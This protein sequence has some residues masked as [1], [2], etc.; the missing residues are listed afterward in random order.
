MART[1]SETPFSKKRVRSAG[2]T[3]VPS[4]PVFANDE[5]S[6]LH[7]AE[8]RAHLNLDS[9]VLDV[10]NVTAS[11]SKPFNR[12][13]VGLITAFPHHEVLIKQLLAGADLDVGS[14]NVSFQTHQDC[15]YGIEEFIASVNSENLFQGKPITCIADIDYQTTRNFSAFLL[16]NWPGRTCNRKRYGR[17]KALVQKLHDRYKDNPK[18]GENISWAIG[19][20]SIETPSESYPDHVFNQLVESSLTHIKFIMQMM[21]RYQQTL[22]EYKGRVVDFKYTVNSLGQI[23]DLPPE[24]NLK[25]VSALTANAV[26]NWPLKVSLEEANDQFSMEWYK[27][28]FRGNPD[29]HVCRALRHVR[30]ERSI[31]H[32]SSEEERTIELHVGQMAY[33][34]QF[35]FTTRTLYP[36]VLFVQLNTGWNLEAVLGLSD[37]LDSHIGEDLIDPDQY[38]LIYGSKWRTDDVLV[39]RS[40]K[41]DPYSVFNILRFVQSVIAPFKGT[42][43]YRQG[44]LWQAIIS[45]N[46]WLRWGLIVA[47]LKLQNVATESVNFLLEHGIKIDNTA[48]KPG[49]ESRRLRTTWET[50]RKEQGLPIETISEMMSHSDLDTTAINYDNDAGSTNLRNKKLR[51]L[52][53][54]WENDF[55]NYEARLSMSTTMTELRAAIADGNKRSVIDKVSKEIGGQTEESIVNL[56]SPEGQT[57][58]SACLDATKPT[59]PDFARFV[60]EGSRCAF[61]NRCCLCRQA[62]IFKEALPYIARRITDIESL[63]GR[64]ATIE[65]ASNYADELEGWED[66]LDRWEPIA[67][68]ETAK[69]LS[70]R[71]EFALPL[72]MRGAS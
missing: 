15:Y 1:K 53:A 11:P 20:G 35:F 33:F 48:M 4:A 39:A 42:V 70:V 63:K 3:E 47:E 59:W 50:K 14:R 52:Q 6:L 22:Q 16:Q 57:Y 17:V 27:R 18:I 24:E 26:P 71:P 58:I 25:Y 46:L 2:K 28:Q 44:V 43:Q 10:R 60:S 30:V 9:V 55:R 62:V 49:V 5:A 36:F 7:R 67:D 66:I 34:C 23:N 64:L 19:P 51:K 45:K 21:Q 29:R 32:Y 68:V 40:N 8:E 12:S 38:A 72:T 56:L 65:W 31:K 37:D 54:D 41:R 13:F 61:F 69:E